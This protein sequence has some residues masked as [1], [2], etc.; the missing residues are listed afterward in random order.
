MLIIE[1]LAELNQFLILLKHFNPSLGNR[2]TLIEKE[3]NEL[4]SIT[5]A[6]LNTMRSKLNKK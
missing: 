4:L 2:I 6:S 5:V 1:R 3:G